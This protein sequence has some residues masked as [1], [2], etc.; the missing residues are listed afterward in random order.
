MLRHLYDNYADLSMDHL[1]ESDRRMREP[2][3]P[4]TPFESLIK[5]INDAVELADHAGAPYTPVQ[6]VNTAY[7]LVEKTGVFEIDCRR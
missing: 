5:Q 2:W 7:G 6:I 4:N 3:D 1:E